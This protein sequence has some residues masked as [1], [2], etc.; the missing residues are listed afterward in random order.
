M[1]VFMEEFFFGPQ[2]EHLKSFTFDWTIMSYLYI[3]ISNEQFSDTTVSDET[4]SKTTFVLHT[5][6]KT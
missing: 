3:F 5:E 6:I 4:Y 2:G 1:K